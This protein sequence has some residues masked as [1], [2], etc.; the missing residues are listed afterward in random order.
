MLAIPTSKEWKMEAN[1]S[2][3]ERLNKAPIVNYINFL[4]IMGEIYLMCVF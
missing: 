4:Y 3:A 1:N 2:A